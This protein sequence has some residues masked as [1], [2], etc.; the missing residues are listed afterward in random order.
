MRTTPA[1]P[2]TD[3]AL[4]DAAKA[5]DDDWAKREEFLKNSP[6]TAFLEGHEVAGSPNSIV[7]TG[8]GACLVTLGDLR[9]LVRA[10]K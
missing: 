10:L 4:A 2:P 8:L 9:A 3:P 5:F 7:I 1:T 6:I